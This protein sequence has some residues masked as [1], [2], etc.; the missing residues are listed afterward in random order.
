MKTNPDRAVRKEQT[1]SSMIEPRAPDGSETVS[2]EW[3]RGLKVVTSAHIG[4]ATGAGLYL[5]VSSLFILPFTE[6]FGWTRGEISSGAALGLLGSLSAPFIGRCADRFG[7]KS[8]ALA[9]AFLMACS[10]IG[11]SQLTGSYIQF[12]MLSALFGAVAPGCSGLVFSRAV[13]SW[14]SKGRGQAL[15]I[16]SAGGSIGAL[17]FTPIVAWMVSRYSFEGGFLTLACLT[18]CLGMPAIAWGLNDRRV[19]QTSQQG[20]AA[21]EPINPGPARQELSRIVRSR[22]FI[23]LA[24]AVFALN[25]PSAGVLTQLDPLLVHNGVDS[26]AFL[27]ALFAASVLVGRIGIGWLFDQFDARLVATIFTIASALGCLM[28]M[29]G[30]PFGAIV[31]AVIL[32]GFL[33]GMETD[34]IGY[35]VGRHFNR[36]Q[37][38]TVF[39]LLFTTSLLGTGLGIVGFGTLY[40]ASLS[41][42]MPLALAA[43]LL[44]IAI[45]GYLSVPRNATD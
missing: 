44:L 38:G 1:L 5:Y 10:F 40:D 17:L 16:M 12:L 36:D 2:A 34:V 7:T 29:S 37:F 30:M 23:A 8:V 39:G 31:A 42:D 35:F 3:R 45:A 19:A 4:M 21:G 28:L 9:F 20:E 18:L 43:G 41:Y 32:I 22:T 6:S 33:Q 26:R 15:G 24:V 13:S 14:F 25:A 27:I 11:L